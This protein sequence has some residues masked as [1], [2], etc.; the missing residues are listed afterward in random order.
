[1][2][3]YEQNIQD[4]YKLYHDRPDLFTDADHASL[5]ELITSLSGEDRIDKISDAIA[6]W[7]EAHPPI[8]NAF[9]ELPPEETTRGAGNRPTR[10]S[11]KEAL[12]LLD[13]MVR[14]DKP[15]MEPPD[16]KPQAPPRT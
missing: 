12:G 13:N 5:S 6:L 8:L 16:S 4:F 3:I 9:V 2:S 15:E 14:S 1:M 7:C 10:L 11:A